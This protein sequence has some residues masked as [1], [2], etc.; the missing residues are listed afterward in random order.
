ME[1]VLATRNRNKIKEIAAILTGYDATIRRIDEFDDVPEVIEDGDTL[2]ANALKKARAVRDATGINALA[3][4]SGLFVDALD[5]APGV[6][7]ARYAGEDGNAARNTRK[8]LSDMSDV[9]EAERGAEFRCVMA[10]A[11]V[12]GV[13]DQLY[14]EKA[15]EIAAIGGFK[16]APDALMSEGILRGRITTENRGAQ[17]FGYDPVFEVDKAGRVRTLA[18][19]TLEEKNEI[20]HRYRALV[21]MR[22][23]LQQLDLTTST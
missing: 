19:M 16:N 18:E 5:G 14:E 23:L 17:G 13:A 6:Y 4:D 15:S 3:D 2:T 10:L 20:S 11:L 1:I 8:V 7:S 9:P 22:G 21:E 12:N